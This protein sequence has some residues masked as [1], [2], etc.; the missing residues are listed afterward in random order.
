MA[1][2]N[3]SKGIEMWDKPCLGAVKPVEGK[4][5]MAL[6][7]EPRSKNPYRGLAREITK[8][9]GNPDVP[10]FIDESKLIIVESRDA[11][12]WEKK[13]DLEIE[14][15]NKV[16]QG[17]SGDD[18]Y[19]IGLEDPDIYEESGVKH[20]YFTIAFKYKEKIGYAV[21]VG[22]A[23]GR[24]LETLRMTKPVLSPIKEFRGFKEVA[25]APINKKGYKMNLSEAQ[26][27][28]N[29]DDFSVVVSAKA[30]GMAGSWDYQKIV[31]DP[32]KMKYGWCKGEISPCRIL[33]RELV[34]PG[35]SLNALIINGREPKKI[36]NG[37]KIYGKFRPGLALY[38]PES[39]EIPW[40][41][42][43]PLLEDPEATTI[44]FASEFVPAD[45]EHGILYAHVNDSFVRAYKISYKAMRKRLPR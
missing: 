9:E 36:V 15:I 33:P 23:E 25:I 41:D 2:K 18:K 43:K 4:R 12:K 1:W 34:N 6:C 17:L 45:S 29:D 37:K 38:N 44:T 5:F 28:V 3:I 40:V 31:V 19:F 7:V 22:H 24:S 39:G 42:S 32:R 30:S 27:V 14:G 10:G 20:I 35:K 16:I 21:Y 11:L 13:K 26:L 8:S